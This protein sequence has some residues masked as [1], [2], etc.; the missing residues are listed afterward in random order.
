MAHEHI[1]GIKLGEHEAEEHT[2]RKAAIRQHLRSFS[3]RYASQH[4][5]CHLESGIGLPH[6][7]PPIQLSFYLLLLTAR[8]NDAF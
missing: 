3:A 5:L 2:R 4:E 7:F 6:S 1:Y 8:G